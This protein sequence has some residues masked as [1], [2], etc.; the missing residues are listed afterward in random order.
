MCGVKRMENVQ[1]FTIMHRHLILVDLMIEPQKQFYCQFIVVNK[2]LEL[3][4]CV[5]DR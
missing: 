5:I 3:E 2:K 4:N 1:K